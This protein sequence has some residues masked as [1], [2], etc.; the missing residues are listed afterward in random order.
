MNHRAR[1]HDYREPAFYML[2]LVAKNRRPFFSTCADDRVV[3]TADGGIVHRFWHK[4]PE[5]FPEIKTSAL[6]IMPDHIHGILRVTRR[7]AKP[8][9][10]AVRAFKSLTTSEL[11]R[12]HNEP[13]L[14]VWEPGY[15]D[16][17]LY[18]AGALRVWAR[19]LMDNPR[20][21]CL[22]KKNP[23]LFRRVEKL[24]HPALPS[25]QNWAGYGN[26]FLLD[27]P[28][29]IAVRVSRKTAPEEIT[30]LKEK[31]LEAVAAGAVVVSPFISPGEKEI[32]R[33]VLTAERGAVILLKP[34]GFP[35]FF[36]PKG[37]YF[38]LCA[39]GRLL[40]LSCGMPT[41]DNAPLT[42]ETC[43]A[44]NDACAR[45]AGGVII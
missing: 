39:E 21:Y 16:H 22:K 13:V 41:P 15:H 35:P 36:K 5:K 10:V 30:A 11:R 38:D 33:A 14:D 25:G 3:F 40:I 29:K 34:N 37:R 17:I 28:G 24:A 45:I 42:R 6:V 7:M 43:L 18:N 12:Q 20:R 27:Y 44:M 2:T 9:G 8:R 4:I 32:A 31:T 23:D 26:W 1:F 19:Y